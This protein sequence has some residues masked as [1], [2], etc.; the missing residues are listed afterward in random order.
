MMY[1]EIQ[2]IR[3]FVAE[4]DAFSLKV[5]NYIFHGLLIYH[6]RLSVGGN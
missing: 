3:M 2:F 4:N 6:R 5:I 1:I